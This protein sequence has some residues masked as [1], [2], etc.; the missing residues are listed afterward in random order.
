MG[1]T[2]ECPYCG[3]ETDV[4]HDDGHGYA[5]GEA[6]RETC[7]ECDKE[8]VFFTNIT[9]S[10]NANKADCLNGGEHEWNPIMTRRK[11]YIEIECTR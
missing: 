3:A 10:Y 7:V 5:E 11:C 2:V 1:D 9:F 6:H 4:C 8:F